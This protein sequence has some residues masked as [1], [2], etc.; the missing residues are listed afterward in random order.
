LRFPRVDDPSPQLASAVNDRVWP[1]VQLQWEWLGGESPPRVALARGAEASPP[2]LIAA[3]TAG[4]ADELMTV[5][6][7]GSRRA[8]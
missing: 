2:R 5:A 7:G 1:M 4:G 8:G 6:D 3:G